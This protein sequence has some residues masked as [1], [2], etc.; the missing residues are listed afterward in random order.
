MEY[1]VTDFNVGFSHFKVLGKPITSS[2]DSGNTEPTVR[3]LKTPGFSEYAV[4]HELALGSTFT[5]RGNDVLVGGK[6]VPG[7]TARGI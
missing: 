6:V 1:T 7:I 5:L 2:V 3:I 4:K